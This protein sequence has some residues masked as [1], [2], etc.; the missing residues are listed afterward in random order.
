MFFL[1]I[2]RIVKMFF[3]EIVAFAV[4]SETWRHVTDVPVDSVTHG[5]TLPIGNVAK[6]CEGPGTFLWRSPY[7]RTN[8][9]GPSQ[10]FAPTSAIAY[11]RPCHRRALRSRACLQLET[12]H[13]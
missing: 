8:E 10:S 12:P 6:D 9:S 7:A 3:L 11:M 1:E 13:M 2:V 4:S 5:G